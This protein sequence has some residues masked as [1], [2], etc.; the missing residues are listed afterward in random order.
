MIV[1]YI[2]HLQ[3]GNF[4]REI[5]VQTQ[6]HLCLLSACSNK[7]FVYNEMKDYSSRSQMNIR[8]LVENKL[9]G[10]SIM[11]TEQANTYIILF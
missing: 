1:I 5:S 11:G 10:D 8:K 3:Y 6:S 2:A 7:R 9:T 4:F